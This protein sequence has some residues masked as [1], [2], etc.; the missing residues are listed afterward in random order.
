MINL[1]YSEESHARLRRRHGLDS[2]DVTKALCRTRLMELVQKKFIIGEIPILLSAS[3]CRS[4]V[5]CH[6]P[7][8][9]HRVTTPRQQ[10]QNVAQ[11]PLALLWNMFYV[12]YEDRPCGLSMPSAIATGAHQEPT[13]RIHNC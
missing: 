1:H 10:L 12:M 5:Y 2:L 8:K 3:L 9:E 6:R 13:S 4:C 11:L 7:E